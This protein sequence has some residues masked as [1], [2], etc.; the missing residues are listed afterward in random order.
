MRKLTVLLLILTL[1]LGAIYFGSRKIKKGGISPILLIC[2]SAA[3][4]IVAYGI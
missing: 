3:A 4:G 2:L 1:L